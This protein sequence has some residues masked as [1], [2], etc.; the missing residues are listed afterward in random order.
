MGDICGIHK[1]E[2]ALCMVTH[3]AVGASRASC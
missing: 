1:V 3:Y 2:G